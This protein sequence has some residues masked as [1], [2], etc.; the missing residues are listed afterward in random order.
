M[1]ILA[2]SGSSSSKSLN[3]RLLRYATSLASQEHPIQTVSVRDIDAPIFSVD[4][5]AESGI[6]ADIET[7]HL[8]AR[9]ADA[10][11]LATPEHN[12]GM[13][14]MLKNVIDWLSR[15][16]S[17][18]KW[19]ARPVL[20]LSTSPGGRGGQTNLQHLATIM[21]FWGAEIGGSFSLGRFYDAWDM[22]QNRPTDPDQAARIQA[23]I[24][25]LI[26]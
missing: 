24:D 1:K 4:I 9:S 17:E 13:P 16:Q 18:K 7:L 15:V 23:L 14:A 6:P 3:H 21:P 22:E 2:L 5:E 25:G 26:A 11:I 8:D 19:C 10:I 20:L 12:G